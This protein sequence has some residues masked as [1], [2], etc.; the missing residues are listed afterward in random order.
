MATTITTAFLAVMVFV[1]TQAFLK[2]V[3]EPIQA[4]RELIGEV[5]HALLFYANVIAEFEV[6]ES[7]AGGRGMK[8]GAEREEVEETRK[9]LRGLAG[10]LRASLWTVPFYDSLARFGWVPSRENVIEAST[11]LVGWSN[12][13]RRDDDVRDK[14]R[15]IIA[16]RL[17]ISKKLGGAG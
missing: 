15:E 2:M 17:G 7:I 12:S 3:L 6:P 5:A 8:I 10:R 13:L 11:Q 14:R 1:L 9:A 16:D 4:Q